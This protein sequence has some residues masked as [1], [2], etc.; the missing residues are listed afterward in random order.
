MSE[1]ADNHLVASM[2]CKMHI[3][4]SHRSGKG[5]DLLLTHLRSGFRRRDSLYRRGF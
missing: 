4:K 5:K 1:R 2:N 3:S